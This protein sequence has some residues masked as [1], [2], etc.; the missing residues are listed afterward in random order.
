MPA[1]RRKSAAGNTAAA[2]GARSLSRRAALL[3]VGSTA[4]AAAALPSRRAAAA[5][6]AAGLGSFRA[7]YHFTVPDNWKNDPQRPIWVNGQY[8]YYYLYNADYLTGSEGTAWR[9][10][11]STDLVRYRD[12]GVAVPKDAIP[13]GDVWS[14]SAVVDEKNTAGFGAGAVIALI[15]MEPDAGTASQAQYLWYSTD[16]GRTFTSHSDDPVLPNPGGKDFRD[17]KVLWDEARGRW[18][19]ALAEGHKIGLYTSADLRSWTYRSGFTRDDLGTLECPD[20]FEIRAADGT[21]HWILAASANGTQRGLPATYA[22]WTGDFDGTTFSPDATEPQ[23][24]DHGPDFYAAVTCE[25]RAADGTVDPAARYAFAWTNNWTY[26]HNTPTLVADGF[27]GTDSLTRELTL[28]RAGDG[29]Y[30]LASRPAPALDR[31]ATGTKKLGDVTV[32]GSKALDVTGTSYEIRAR[33]R[34]TPGTTENLGF[35]LRKAPGGLRH[36]DVGVYVAGGFAYVNRGGT[37]TPGGP[38]ETHT[39][40][41]A[42]AGSLDVRVFVDRTTVELFVGDGRHVHT[43]Q[44]F[45]LPGDDRIALYSSGGPAVFEDLRIITY[46]LG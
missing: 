30:H 46:D 17:P 22:Y 29:T 20:L 1:G 11:T 18:V 16:H 13:A 21:A 38:A 8:L 25:K 5:P 35:Q 34:W 6:K 33:L 3:S 7:A 37:I 23:W 12:E 42:A 40:V 31:Y 14:G 45:P 28:E 15:T 26:P 36:I 24:L 10:A 27:N 2:G 19:A 32:D 9:L 39:P 43:H 41:D 4:L 44:A